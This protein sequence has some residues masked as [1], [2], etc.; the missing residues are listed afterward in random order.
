MKENF[1]KISKKP[2]DRARQED[3]GFCNYSPFDIE[4]ML[5]SGFVRLLPTN[6]TSKY[7][8][9]YIN[10]KSGDT[11][12]FN[13][14]FANYS[15]LVQ[16]SIPIVDAIEGGHVNILTSEKLSEILGV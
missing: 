12:S 8:I 14:Y 4:T 2:K 16:Q 7:V 9:D 1:K 11:V 6:S 15:V 5:P 10:E 13:F 3:F